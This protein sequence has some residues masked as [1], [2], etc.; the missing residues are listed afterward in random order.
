MEKLVEIIGKNEEQQQQAVG[1]SQ[2]SGKK[3]SSKNRRRQRRSPKN[4]T[5]TSTNSDSQPSIDLS[6]KLFTPPLPTFTPTMKT[7]LSEIEANMFYLPKSMSEMRVVDLER[8]P[9]PSKQPKSSNQVKTNSRAKDNQ[10]KQVGNT[11]TNV[12]Q[13]NNSNNNTPRNNSALKKSVSGGASL[14]NSQGGVTYEAYWSNERIEE[15]LA[16]RSAIQGRLRINQRSFEDA[17]VSDPVSCFMFLL[18][19]IFFW[20]SV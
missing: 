10:Q 8:K 1:T 9:P 11:P 15:A 20:M 2:S 16:N 3:K 14:V 18:Q 12:R 5:T 17:F 7:S 13:N 6:S 4:T 19:G